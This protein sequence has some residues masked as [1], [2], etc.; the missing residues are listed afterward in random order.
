MVTSVVG[1]DDASVVV[2]SAEL[3]VVAAEAPSV[4]ET[5]PVGVSTAVLVVVVVSS[6]GDEN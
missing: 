5:G 6:L 4:V 3:S 1:V 2:R